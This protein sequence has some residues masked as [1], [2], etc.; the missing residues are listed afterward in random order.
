VDKDG[1]I[2]SWIQSL[3]DFGSG[4]TVEGMGSILH[5]RGKNLI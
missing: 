5:D 3:Y 1:N 2:A 4:V